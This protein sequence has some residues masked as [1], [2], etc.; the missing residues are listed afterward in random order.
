MRTP[1]AL[2]SLLLLTLAA[3]AAACPSAGRQVS[4]ID[5]PAAPPPEVPAATAPAPRVA[6]Q[7]TRTWAYT[8]DEPARFEALSKRFGNE[9]YLKA[10]IDLNDDHAYYFDVNVYRFHADFVFREF[11][12]EAATANRREAFERNYSADK[13][14]YVLVTVVNHL[15]PDIWTFALWE[16]DQATPEHIKIAYQRLSKSFFMAPKLRFLPTSPHLERVAKALG[17]AVP[18]I[19]NDS[20]Y[21]LSSQHTFNIGR[22]VGKLRIV[23]AAD[24]AAAL[25]FA[26]DEIVI[27][28]EPLPQITAVSGIISEQFSTPLAHVNL[29]AAAWGIPHI[30]LRDASQR[31]AK[32]AGQAVFFEAREDGHTLRAATPDE[33]KLI[34][35]SGRGGG[36]VTLPR[37]DLTVKD[38]R[39]L[40]DMRSKNAD[41]YGAKA[42]NLG[43][44]ARA[45]I[46]GV[47]VPRGFGVPIFYFAQHMRRHGLDKRVDALL[48]DPKFAADAA[49]RKAKLTELRA[50]IVAAPVSEDLSRA[51]S[52]LIEDFELPAGKGVFVRSSTNAEDLPGFTGAGLYTTVP[53]VIGPEALGQALK[54][55]WASVWNFRA[56]EE[57]EFHGIDH[58]AVY[59]GL[60]VQ[61]G[62]DATAAGVLITTN[63]FDATDRS[64]FTINAKS[65]LGMRV[66]GGKKVPE[67]L[68]YDRDHRAI[69]VLSRSDESTMLVFDAQGGIKEVPTEAGQPILTDRRII[70]LGDAAAAVQA[71]FD[72]G[73]QDIEWL[74]EGERLFIVQSRPFVTR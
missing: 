33:A 35:G 36:V 57:R 64:R 55:V 47:V 38:I 23:T 54:T 71:L 29:R 73:P 49:Y 25:T 70:A 24:R 5:T 41:V 67:Q 40:P 43:E 19:T 21:K 44:I 3:A 1:P 69:K 51:V 59:M 65:G 2:S 17:G 9:R 72:N 68:L 66:V 31:Y 52:R 50:A 58:R 74:F 42:A 18:V 14:D 10:L 22:R 6:L 28:A 34:D 8:L 46:N 26:P 15:D 45:A 60:L 39:P 4:G 62:V 63:I 7:A 11:F 37:A 32:L 61:V 53:N 16:G 56:Y 20:L 30:G 27:L 12:S 48:A 13:P